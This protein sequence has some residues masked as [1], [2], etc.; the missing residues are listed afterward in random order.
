LVQRG[1][2]SRRCSPYLVC[3]G[4][5]GTERVDETSTCQLDM[6]TSH[7]QYNNCLAHIPIL[8]IYKER[9]EKRSERQTEREGERERQRETEG[10]GRGRKKTETERERERQRQRD[11]DRERDRQRQRE[12]ETGR[13]R[14][15]ERQRET[16]IWRLTELMSC[17]N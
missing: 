16:E 13:D 11:R 15:R 6:E 5:L 4:G 3:V 9:S 12:T 8:C 10:R 14:E 7:H 1:L 17:S 2:F